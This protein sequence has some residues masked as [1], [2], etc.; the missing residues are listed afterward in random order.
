MEIQEKSENGL[1][2]KEVSLKKKRKIKG[3]KWRKSDKLISLIALFISLGTFVTFAYQNYLIQKQQYRSVMPYLMTNKFT[4]YDDNQQALTNIYISNNGVGPAFIE[5]IEIRYEGKVYHS[6]GEFLYKGVYATIPI[7][8]GMTEI[9]S[10]Y[11]IPSGEGVTFLDSN[12]STAAKVLNEVYTKM[13]M[14]VTYTSL[15]DEK[16]SIS[17]KDLKPVQL[18]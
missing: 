7:K 6:V 9:I 3:S 17:S 15:Y 11:A 4:G 1:T 10:G 8:T 12:D 2:E 16:W 13:E 18:D 14:K 5:E